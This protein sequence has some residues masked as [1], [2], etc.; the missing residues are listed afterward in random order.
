LADDID[1]KTIVDGIRMLRDIYR[2]PAF[3][4]L[5]EAHV[6]P[7]ASD[8]SEQALLQFACEQGS[9]VFHPSGTCRMGSDDRAVVDPELKVNGVSRLRV[10]DASVMP[11]MTSA[12]INAPTIM[13]GEKGAALVINERSVDR[14]ARSE[15]LA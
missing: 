12:N 1:R 11:R 14:H 2:Q 7:Q 4:D 13:I 10:I 15:A 6:L 3:S 5:I 8:L 9:T